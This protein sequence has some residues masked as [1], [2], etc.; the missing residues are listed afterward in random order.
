MLASLCHIEIGV[1][2]EALLDEVDMGR[3][4]LACHFSLDFLRDKTSVSARNWPPPPYLHA[5]TES[6]NSLAADNE[7]AL[8]RYHF[9]HENCGHLLE[10]C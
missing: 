3:I 5:A 6:A 4:A 7:L 9:Q 1:G 2:M 8:M 10:P